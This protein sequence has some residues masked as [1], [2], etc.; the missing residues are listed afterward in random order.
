MQGFCSHTRLCK[1]LSAGDEEKALDDSEGE[2][3]IESG[4][5]IESEEAIKPDESIEPEGAIKPDE[6]IEPESSVEFGFEPEAADEL[7]SP[8]QSVA[9]SCVGIGSDN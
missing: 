6:A 2:G 1:S 5:A 7:E 8:S 3:A 4:K 9:L